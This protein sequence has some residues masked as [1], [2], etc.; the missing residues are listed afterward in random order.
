[1]RWGKEKK[2]FFFSFPEDSRNECGNR[3]VSEMDRNGEIRLAVLKWEEAF[4]LST[5][6]RNLI[7]TG[8]EKKASIAMITARPSVTVR[9][10]VM[11]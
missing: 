1:M 5:F 8:R 7:D 10:R 6:S 3:K 11:W 9:V 2:S 4:R